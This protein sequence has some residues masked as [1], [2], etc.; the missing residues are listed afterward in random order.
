[1]AYK[2]NIHTENTAA[3]SLFEDLLKT[4]KQING[5]Y[6]DASVQQLRKEISAYKIPANIE[7]YRN[8]GYPSTSVN[9]NLAAPKKW[10]YRN[11][12]ALR[13][14]IADRTKANEKTS[15]T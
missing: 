15:W 10:S 13:Q 14:L 2:I 9:L 3:A 6:C 4:V 7:S 12:M 11:M 1:M 5:S 8:I